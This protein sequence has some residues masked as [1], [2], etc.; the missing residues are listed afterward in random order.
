M[1]SSSS[2]LHAT[3][4]YTSMSSDYHMPSW[5]IPLM[6]AYEPEPKAPEDAPQSPD[7]ALLSPAHTLVYLDYVAPSDDDLT[8]EDQPLLASASPTALSPDYL[9]DSEPVKDDPEED[10]KAGPI[11]YPFEEEEEAPL[12]LTLSASYVPDSVPSSEE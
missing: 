4:T 6:D 3:V 5:A 8:A 1:S 2:S 9:A 7:Q 12:A 11:D 10:P